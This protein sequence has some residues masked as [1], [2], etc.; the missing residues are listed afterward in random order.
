MSNIT[1]QSQPPEINLI[2]DGIKFKL[3]TSN[4]YSSTGVAAELKLLFTPDSPYTYTYRDQY[5]DINFADTTIRFYFRATPDESG[6]ELRERDPATALA[7]FMDQVKEDLQANYYVSK[8]YKVVTWMGTGPIYG[9][10]LDA[11]EKGLEYSAELGSFTVSGLSESNQV[12]GEDQIEREN[13]RIMMEAYIKGTEFNQSTLLGTDALIPDNNNDCLFDLKEFFKDQLETTFIFPEVDTLYSEITGAVVAAFFRYG[14]Y[15]DN[16]EKKMISTFD[17]PKYILE[18]GVSWLDKAFYNEYGISYFE[19]DENSKKFLTWAPQTKTISRTA[20]EKLYF[21]FQESDDMDLLC[22]MTF[23]DETEQTITLINNLSVSAYSVYEFLLSFSLL[24]LSDYETGK[25]IEKYE[26]WIRNNTDDII[27]EVRTYELDENDYFNE[28]LFLFKNSFGNYEYLRCTGVFERENEFNRDLIET[29]NL[30]GYTSKSY[31]K[32]NYH[33]EREQSFSGNIGYVDKNYKAYLDD[34]CGSNE[35]YEI[36]GDLIF[37]V[38]LTNKRVFQ[39]KDD[40]TLYDME[41]E[42]S[43]AYTD[44][45]FSMEMPDEVI[46][47]LFDESG[48]VITDASGAPLFDK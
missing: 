25:T 26:V 43:R 45:Y 5:F 17:N 24:G 22:K 14:E 38:I 7:D 1:I 20:K 27:S 2:D 47:L 11:R 12:D 29:E 36:K 28:R 15:Y 35:V 9:V 39:Y 42:Y 41:F 34:F 40:E 6:T 4:R 18:G 33:I 37:P 16:E 32:K 13:Y 10:K 46:Y 21:L 44:L 8:Y 31:Q 48:D 3:R 23:N 19:Y 30:E